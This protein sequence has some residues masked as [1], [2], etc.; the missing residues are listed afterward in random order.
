MKKISPQKVLSLEIS[1]QR[2]LKK[3]KRIRTRKDVSE[4]KTY[5]LKKREITLKSYNSI[6]EKYPIKSSKKRD[7]TIKIPKSFSMY[8]NPEGVLRKIHEAALAGQTRNHRKITIDHSDCKNHDLAAEVLLSSAIACAKSFRTSKGA[9]F[10]VNG[11][12]PEDK[13]MRRLLRGVGI[14]KDVASHIYILKPKDELQIFKR[15]SFLTE[16]VN[17]FGKDKKTRVTEDFTAHM[18]NCLGFI[19]AQ[20]DQNEEKK[21]NKYLGEILSNAEEHSGQKIWQITSYLDYSNPEDLSCEI[22]IFNIGKTVFDTFEEKKG[23]P[24]VE[25]LRKDYVSRHSNKITE[26]QLTIVYALQQNASSKLD[27]ACD[28]GQGTRYLIELFHHFTDE[29]NRIHQVMEK[30][31]C[32]SPKMFIL[33]GRTM[34]KF[35]GTYSPK[36]KTGSKMVF[37]MNQTNDLNHAPDV[38]VVPFFRDFKFPGTAIYINFTLAK[39]A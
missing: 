39:S 31:L 14:V 17:I 20:L 23:V 8:D 32:S 1:K 12:L 10:N 13:K 27:E 26:E 2:E 30:N 25:R 6:C 28:R 18:N 15:E 37:A 16:S 33:S 21:L 5:I 29:C 9:K 11:Y 4:K 36:L 22:F 35:D 7:Y 24:Q 19:N 34:L 38:A 3:K